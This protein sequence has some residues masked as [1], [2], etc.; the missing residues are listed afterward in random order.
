MEDGSYAIIKTFNNCQSNIV[1]ANELISYRIAKAL[2]LP[3]SRS[4]VCLISEDTDDPYG[5]LTKDAY[6]KGFFSERIDRT[7][8]F[9]AP[10]MV[11]LVQNKADIPRSIVF[12][13]LIYNKDR[14]QGNIL[15]KF[16]KTGVLFYLID[17]THVFNKQCLWNKRELELCIEE[18]DFLD[19]DILEY[20]K[21]LYGMFFQSM[22]MTLENFLLISSDY[23]SKINRDMLEEILDNVPYEWEVSKEDGYALIE[24]ILYR[25][26]NLDEICKVIVEYKIV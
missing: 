18:D 19:T 21:Y 15:L 16:L 8:V 10:T 6:G 11:N 17:H 13:H 20:N 3:V 4:G 14:N 12:D 24:Y 1:L 23:Q 2:N 26:K 22:S 7:T 5:C 25:L 9:N